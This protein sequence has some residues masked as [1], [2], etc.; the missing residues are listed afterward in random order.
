MHPTDRR[1]KAAFRATIA[2]GVAGLLLLVPGINVIL[3]I[4][5]MLPLWTI[6]GMGVPGLGRELHGFFIPSPVGWSIVAVVVWTAC[7]A[8]F[9]ATLRRRA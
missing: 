6:S 3:L 4:G 5:V 7:F 9:S 2:T 1:V 8:F